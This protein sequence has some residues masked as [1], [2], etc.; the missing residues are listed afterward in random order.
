MTIELTAQTPI[1]STVHHPF[2]SPSGPGLWHVKGMELPAYIQ[3]VAHALIRNGHAVD[4]SRAISMAVGIVENWAAGHD[5]QGNKV[6]TE[7]QTAAAAA[8]AEWEA[9]RAQAKLNNTVN[10]SDATIDLASIGFKALQTKLMAQ[11]HSAEDAARIAAAVGRKKFG[12]KKFNKKIKAGMNA[13]ASLA[14]IR[15]NSVNLAMGTHA[16]TPNMS[17]SDLQAHLGNQHGIRVDGTD[18]TKEKMQSMHQICH[19]PS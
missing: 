4:E 14:V 1:V 8:I 19:N 7:V 6:S 3:N 17:K 10:R 11:G 15:N 13:S 5:G 2:G 18:A 12:N 9:K 16:H